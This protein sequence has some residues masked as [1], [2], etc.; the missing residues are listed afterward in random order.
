MWFTILTSC[1]YVCFAIFIGINMIGIIKLNY[2]RD[3]SNEP[4]YPYK[5][6]IKKKTKA[7]IL[8]FSLLIF[9]MFS[10]FFLQNLFS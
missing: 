9:V 5:E 7:V 3:F 10:I 8:L 6:M 2:K 1:I 4:N